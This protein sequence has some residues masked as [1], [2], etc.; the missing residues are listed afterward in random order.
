MSN[1]TLS[2]PKIPPLDDTVGAM[3]IGAACAT[4]L[5]GIGTLQTYNYYKL[6]PKD[7]ALIKWVVCVL[8]FFEFGHT[9]S[10]WH[11]VYTVTVTFYGQPQEIDVPQHSLVVT[12]LFSA[13]IYTIVQVFFA[14][15]IRVIS[16]KWP[17]TV[18]CWIISVLRAVCTFAMFGILMHIAHLSQ[19]A[20]NYKWVMITG[21]SLGVGVDVIIAT[22][23]CYCLWRIRDSGV[24]ATKRIVDTLLVW[25]IETGL[26]TGGASVALLALFLV[27]DDLTWIAF[28]LVLA[29][30]FSNSLL[31]SLNGRQHFRG[32]KEIVNLNTAR[33]P[34]VP[35]TAP[36]R[37]IAFEMSTVTHSVTDFT[38]AKDPE[39]LRTLED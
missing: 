2:L 12:I 17:L 4:F 3:Q 37:S 34:T 21:L 38:M 19:V 23:M 36:T 5:F 14:N 39:R 28:Y 29:K 25:T 22:A 31:A 11:A 30:L 16:G 6:F 35:V 8:W 24:S 7:S 10:T 32:D 26:A 13:T 15:R 27:R 1:T 18:V 9:I 33:S 20:T